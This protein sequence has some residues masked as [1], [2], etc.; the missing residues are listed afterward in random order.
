MVVEVTDPEPKSK[1]E[2]IGIQASPSMCDVK[3]Q[4]SGYTQSKGNIFQLHKHFFYLLFLIVGMQVIIKPECRDVGIQCSL[5]ATTSVST[6][7]K[8][9]LSHIVFSDSDISD[10]EADKHHHNQSYVPSSESCL[11]YAH[12]TSMLLLFHMFALFCKVR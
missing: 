12:F 5:H 2:E 1:F 8:Q 6:P 9:N 7:K 10:I 11:S 4:F 3:T